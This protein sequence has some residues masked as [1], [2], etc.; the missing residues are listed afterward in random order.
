M[1]ASN[2]PNFVKSAEERVLYSMN[3]LTFRK[4]PVGIYN[5]YFSSCLYTSQV[6]DSNGVFKGFIPSLPCGA[7][8]GASSHVPNRSSKRRCKVSVRHLEGDESDRMADGRVQTIPAVIVRVHQ[9]L[10]PAAA[11]PCS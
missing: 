5:D 4:G 2:V 9:E 10:Q 1:R 11:V 6:S 8:G 7:K 3:A